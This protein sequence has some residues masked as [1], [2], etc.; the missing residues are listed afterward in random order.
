VTSFNTWAPSLFAAISAK[1]KNVH[2]EKLIGTPKYCP[3]LSLGR[4][5]C[6]IE[7]PDIIIYPTHITED[8]TWR[9]C[10]LMR[11]LQMERGPV[12]VPLHL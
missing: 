2:F 4:P 5:P 7:S 11:V 12:T 3:H 8:K 9:L 6:E 10:A 1:N